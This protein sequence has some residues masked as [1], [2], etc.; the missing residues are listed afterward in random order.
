M[1]LALSISSSTTVLFRPNWSSWLARGAYI[2]TIYGGLLSLIVIVSIMDNEIPKFIS[3]LTFV[4]AF[5]TAVYTAFLFAQAKARDFWQSPLLPFEMIIHS[6]L[7]GLAVFYLLLKYLID[8]NLSNVA[9]M[10][11]PIINL[12]LIFIGAAI[13]TILL[14]ALDKASAPRP[15]KNPP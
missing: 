6:L 8:D 5:L 3:W 4:F 10:S 14:L 13:S 1:Y 7:T 2:I 9:V 15:K 11:D 12:D